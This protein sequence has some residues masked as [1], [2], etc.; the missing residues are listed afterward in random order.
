M[1]IYTPISE[2]ARPSEALRLSGGSRIDVKTPLRDEMIWMPIFVENLND[3]SDR[4]I[5]DVCIAV[6]LA[7]PHTVFPT[8]K[9]R[10]AAEF[11]KYAWSFRLAV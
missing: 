6:F 9:I 3:N 7:L 8:P 5:E 1:T 4:S 2:C 11:C 10:G